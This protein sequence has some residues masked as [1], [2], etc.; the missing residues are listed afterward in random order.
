MGTTQPPAVSSTDIKR[1]ECE[2]DHTPPPDAQVKNINLTTCPGNLH[3]DKCTRFVISA[4]TFSA[5][6]VTP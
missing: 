6:K 1:P 2:T 3:K 5:A 4:V